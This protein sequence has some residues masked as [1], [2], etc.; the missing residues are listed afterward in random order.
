MSVFLTVLM[1]GCARLSLLIE[2][3]LVPH[4]EAFSA[5]RF[6]LAINSFS[7]GVNLVSWRGGE[8]NSKM[9]EHNLATPS[10]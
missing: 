5:G 2:E 1:F 6:K 4:L 10:G 7:G 8:K 3:V 9:K